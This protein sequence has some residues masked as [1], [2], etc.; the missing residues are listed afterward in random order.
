MSKVIRWRIVDGTG[1]VS[2]AIKL[3]EGGGI[4]DHVE[5]L[6][7]DGMSIG[8]RCQDGVQIRPANYNTFTRLFTFSATVTDEQY[9][10]AWDFLMAQVGKKYDFAACAGVLFQR[11]WRDDS[12][13][14]CSEL[15]TRT[16]EVGKIIGELPVGVNR[17]TPQHALLISSAMFPQV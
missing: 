9:K 3:V 8:A 5:F 16:M 15:W 13:W 10:A 11:D 12:R 7:D 14:M 6:T 1:F 4:V 17:I 2:K